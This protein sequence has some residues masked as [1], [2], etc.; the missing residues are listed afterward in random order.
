MKIR[1]SI[2]TL[3]I[4]QHLKYRLEATLQ[5]HEHCPKDQYLRPT[6]SSALFAL[7][8]CYTKELEETVKYLQSTLVNQ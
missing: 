6:E 5:L 2:K 1:E 7:G 4:R 8:S 3:N